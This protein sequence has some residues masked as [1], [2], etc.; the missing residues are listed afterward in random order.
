VKI[1][2]KTK[3]PAQRAHSEILR[4]PDYRFHSGETLRF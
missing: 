2:P 3:V 1:L 4:S